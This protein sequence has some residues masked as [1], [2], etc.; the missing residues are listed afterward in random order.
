MCSEKLQVAVANRDTDRRPLIVGQSVESLMTKW[1]LNN[2][3]LQYKIQTIL[4]FIPT[5]FGQPW[6]FPWEQ[7]VHTERHKSLYI[8]RTGQN[9]LRTNNYNHCKGLSICAFQYG[10]LED[11]QEWS[12]HVGA[13]LILCYCISLY[14]IL[15]WCYCNVEFSWYTVKVH[16]KVTA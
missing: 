6:P 9:R 15:H 13:I 1:I 12:K 11:C 10:S 4:I 7:F 5:C 14:R 3:L 2:D 16:C 8:S